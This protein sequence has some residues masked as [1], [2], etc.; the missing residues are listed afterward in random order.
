VNDRLP[1]NEATTAGGRAFPVT[2]WGLVAGVQAS[3]TE[4]RREALESL[5][6][7]YWKP[8]FFFVRR[9]W[10]KGPEDAQDL[11][12]A[13]FLALLEGDALQKYAPGRGSFRTYLKTVLRYFA[14]DQHEALLT[15]KRGGGRKAVPID[16][17]LLPAEGTAAGLDADQAF[18][19]AWKKEV[20]E[21]AVE[22]TRQWFAS[23]DRAVRFRAFEEY[24]LSEGPARPTYAEVAARIGVKESDV[25]NYLFEVRDRIRS[26][27]RAEL[28]QTLS[29][30]DQLKE[31]WSALFE[32]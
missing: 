2:S 14:A 26:E 19:L 11:T 21:R 24:D 5:C 16:P 12:Q 1:E 6:R 7:R 32:R 30:L 31:E 27:A 22:R 10:S 25:R 20:L 13:F 28:G 15:L 29:D 4:A 17:A 23:T 3:G 18:D 8:V 9:T